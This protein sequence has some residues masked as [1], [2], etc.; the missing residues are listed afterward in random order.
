[1]KR[2]SHIALHVA[3][4]AVMVMAVV[5]PVLMPPVE[6]QTDTPTPTSTPTPT[7]LDSWNGDFYVYNT[8]DML[9]PDTAEGIFTTDSENSCDTETYVNLNDDPTEAGTVEYRYVG[10]SGQYFTVTSIDIAWRGIQVGIEYTDLDGG[11][12]SQSYS[13]VSGFWQCQPDHSGAVGTHNTIGFKLVGN[14]AVARVRLTGHWEAPP[15]EPTASPLP[16]QPTACVTVTPTPPATAQ[17]TPTPFNLTPHPSSTPGAPTATPTATATPGIF[18]VGDISKFD[19]TLSPWT[20]LVS[21]RPYGSSILAAWSNVV[22]AD[23]VAGAAFLPFYIDYDGV[24]YTGSAPGGAIVFSRPSGFPKPIRITGEFKSDPIPQNKTNYVRLFYLSPDYFGSSPVWVFAGIKALNPTWSILDF[25]VSPTA[26][27]TALVIDSVNSGT[28][29]SSETGVTS[30]GYSID[31]DGNITYVPNPPGGRVA[32]AYADDLRIYAGANAISGSYP[33]C[34]G[35]GGS[36]KPP[37]PT[38]QCKVNAIVTNVYAGCTTPTDTLD[39][40]GWISYYFCRLWHYLWFVNENRQQITDIIDR[41]NSNE[42]I[43][44]LNEMDDVLGVLYETVSNVGAVYEGNDY[45]TIDWASLFAGWN[46]D[47]GNIT[48]GWNTTPDPINRQE[49][50][51]ACPSVI[52][53]MNPDVQKSACFVIWLIKIKLRWW[54]FLQYI[55]DASSIIFALTVILD[56]VGKHG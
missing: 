27:V 10:H 38:K 52:A 6:A 4:L 8:A 29:F 35:T 17:R 31:F 22:G 45:Y 9:Y 37:I 24:A 55:L 44:T 48:A 46:I 5:A 11:Y 50:L 47:F 30:A 28:P 2:R 43:G 19:S 13:G 15:T 49:V 51:N 54:V 25:T 23:Q 56:W 14:A 41:Q 7:T 36:G 33:V 12:T 32:G 1:M 40:A 21:D 34:Q 3:L 20:A 26:T 16:P 42:P 18:F 53:N 39:L